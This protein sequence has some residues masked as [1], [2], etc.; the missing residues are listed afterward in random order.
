AE[1]VTQATF[2]TF[3]ERAP[4]FEGRSHVRTWLFGILYKKIAEAR[5]QLLRDEP[6]DDIKERLNQRFGPEGS[7][8]SPPRPADD[9]IY[10]TQVREGIE[11]CLETLP[12][13]QRVAFVLRDAEGLTTDEICK[14]LEVNATNFGVLL[15]RGRNRLRECLER[16]GIKR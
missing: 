12:D 15:Y 7:W 9:Q 8:L 13:K 4:E 2:A 3:L 11:D 5:R 10:Y 14:I 1:D 16:K 6:V